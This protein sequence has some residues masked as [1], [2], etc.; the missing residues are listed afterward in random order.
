MSHEMLVAVEKHWP[1][2]VYLPAVLVA[3]LVLMV[4]T[5]VF[6]SR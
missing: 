1:V 2:F 5:K 4:V 3:I 6:D